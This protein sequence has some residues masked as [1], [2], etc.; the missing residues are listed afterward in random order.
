MQPLESEIH[1]QVH[2]GP[3][4]HF[5]HRV[6]AVLPGKVTLHGQIFSQLRAREGIPRQ[7]QGVV[8]NPRIPRIESHAGHVQVMERGARDV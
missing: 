6:L 4:R 8:G 1:A 5:G 3:L 2:C 7:V